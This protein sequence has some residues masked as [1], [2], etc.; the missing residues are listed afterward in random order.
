EGLRQRLLV[1]ARTLDAVSPLA[2][3]QR[4]FAIATRSRDGALLRDSAMIEEG[5]TLDLR[6]G[7]GALQAKVSVKS[8]VK[9]P[10]V[11]EP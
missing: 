4:G 1:A 8:S 11:D 7:R 9:T 10:G 2:T 3:L 5:E 6:L